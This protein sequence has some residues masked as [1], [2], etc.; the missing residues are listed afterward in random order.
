ML[1]LII[2]LFCCINH[3]RVAIHIQLQVLWLYLSLAAVPIIIMGTVLEVGKLVIQYGLHR[4]WSRAIRWLKTYPSHCSSCIDVDNVNG[5]IWIPSKAH[6][7]QNLTRHSPSR[8]EILEGK[9]LAEEKYIE[10]QNQ[11]LLRIPK[12]RR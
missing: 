4:Y 3:I 6:V 7:Q 10:R 12:Q 2:N 9:I 5:Y 8:I 11:V 1:F